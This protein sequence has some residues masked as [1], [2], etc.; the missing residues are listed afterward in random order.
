M[1]KPAYGEKRAGYDRE[2]TA[3]DAKI[4]TDQTDEKVLS[5]QANFGKCARESEAM[6]QSKT[7]NDGISPWF[8]VFGN[9]V[10]HGNKNDRRGDEWFCDG[11]WQPH[12]TIERHAKRYRMGNG[13]GGNLP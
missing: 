2:L 5:R 10:F 4:K 9:N 8:D 12:H 6:N 1:P 11:G 3:F 7:K 13:E